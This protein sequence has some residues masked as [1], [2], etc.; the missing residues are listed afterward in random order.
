MKFV[1]REGREERVSAGGVLSCVPADTATAGCNLVSIPFPTW[2]AQAQPS[3][4]GTALTP[5]Q[6]KR[7]KLQKYSSQKHTPS[8][9]KNKSL[10]LAKG[11][12]LTQRAKLC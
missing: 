7:S 10:K 3:S 4:A 5:S 11:T 2:P 6:H 9:Q 8:P 12:S 1:K